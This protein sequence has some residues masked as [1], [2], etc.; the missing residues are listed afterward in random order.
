M[1]QY[2]VTPVAGE[3]VAGRRVNHGDV[4]SLTDEQAEYELARGLI[5]L[6][7]PSV[8]AEAEAAKRKRR[9]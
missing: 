5:V 2:I 9:S 3:W 4:I 8:A 7:T 6:A 1:K